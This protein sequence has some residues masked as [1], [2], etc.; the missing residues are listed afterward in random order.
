MQLLAPVRSFRSVRSLR[1]RTATAVGVAATAAALVGVPSAG[2]AALG[3]YDHLL[4]PET[5]CAGQT[6]HRLPIAS[7]R[8]TMGCM[9]QYARATHG[10][11]TTTLA[12]LDTSAQNKAA[13]ILRCKQF[14]HTAC[15]RSWDYWI[16][17]SGVRFTRWGENIAWGSDSGARSTPRS[18]MR[19]W[20]HSDGHRANLLNPY[21]T[22]HG[23]G[24]VKGT[25]NGYAAGIWV[26]HFGTR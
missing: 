12:A 9:I 6:D 20:L 2:A 15:G 25:F 14:S 8:A 7:Q 23:V 22:S 3:T 13:D 19:A 26:Q 10:V 21:Y 1:A 18:I 24:L 4:A 17:A 5:S 11:R 16:K